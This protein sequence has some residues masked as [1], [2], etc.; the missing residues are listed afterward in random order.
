[1]S[2]YNMLFGKNPNR[3]IILALIGLK[4]CDVQR[5]RDCGLTKDG[6]YIYTRTGGGNREAYPNELLTSNQW[7]RY[8]EDDEYDSTYATYYFDIPDEIKEDVKGLIEPEKY[9]LSAK[10][11]SW[12]NKTLNRPET[13]ND[14]YVKAYNSQMNTIRRLQEGMHVSQAFNGH[15]I[16]PLSDYGMQQMLR[17][18]EKNDGEF[19]AYW[20]FLP[21]KFKVL[22][23]EARWSFDKQRPDLEQDKV[24][25]GID[26]IWEIDYEVWE[27]Y[28]KKFGEK[29][30]KSISKM[31]E[32]I[33]RMNE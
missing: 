29:Y 10:L 6:I 32:Q 20:Y 33:Q 7:Y 24:R 14:K 28:K 16:I 1:M 19:I 15:T 23:N 25:I 26:I 8:D 9:G 4:E 2:L 5:F 22:Q 3:D 18:I 21:Y 11:I 17:E 13:E 30:P 27:R 31:E 12:I